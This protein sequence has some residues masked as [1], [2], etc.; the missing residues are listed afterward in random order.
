MD[1]LLSDLSELAVH[2]DY[3]Y[4]SQK[5]DLAIK[6]LEL[7]EKAMKDRFP[8]TKYHL[9]EDRKEEMI[10]YLITSEREAVNRE[11]KDAKLPEESH[12]CSEF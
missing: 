8:L 4:N 7:R 9:L 5:K 12:V 6:I 10:K 1:Q 11:L 3:G 2:G